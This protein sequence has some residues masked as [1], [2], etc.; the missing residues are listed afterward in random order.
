MKNLPIRTQDRTM[1]GYE[2]MG[3][4]YVHLPPE[5]P[6]LHKRDSLKVYFNV[7]R[8]R[9][10]YIIIPIILVIP[11]LVASSVFEESSYRASAQIQIEPA[12]PKVISMDSIFQTVLREDDLLTEYQLIR[13]EEHLAEVVDRLELQD[14]LVVKN[15]LMSRVKALKS[16]AM[17]VVKRLKSRAFALVGIT[18]EPKVARPLAEGVDLRRLAA[19]NALKQAL[20]VQ[21]QQGGQLVDITVNGLVPA[22]VALQANTVAEVYIDKNFDKKQ[23]GTQAAIEKLIDQTADLRQKMYEAEVQIDQFRQDR[24]IT[25]HDPDDRG[26]AIAATLTRLENEY[27]DARKAREEV[28]GRLRNLESLARRDIRALKTVPT[29]LDQHMISSIMRLRGQYLDLEAQIASNRR[30]YRPKHPVMVRLNTQLAQTR[31]AVNAEFQKGIAALRAE[32]EV[33]RERESGILQQLTEQKREAQ[34]A[35]AAL[36]DFERK[37]HEAESYR[38]LYRQTSRQLRVLQM[39]QATIINNV[40]LIKRAIAPLQ[41][42]P[43]NAF[44]NFFVGIVL[45]GCLGVGFAFVREYLDNRFKEA[46]EVEPFLQ[47]PFLGVV[48]HYAQGKGRVYEPVSLREPGSVAAESYRILRTRLQSAA[49]RMKTL[50]I[51]S[52]LPSEGKSTTTAN[53][54]IAFARLGLRVLLVDIDLRRPSLH[55]HFWISNSEGLATALL[56]GGDWQNFLQDTPVANLKVLP[57]GFNTHNPS[58]LLSLRTTQKL[59]DEF[60]QAFDFIIFDGPI[61]LS[62]P[63]VEIVAPWMDGVV[64]VHY[65]ERC[66]KPSVLN[67]KMLLE[68]VNST[69][70]GVVFNNIRRQDQKYYHQQRTYYSQNLYS[71]AE[72]YDLDRDAVR[73]LEVGATEASKHGAVFANEE[74]APRADAD[75]SQRYGD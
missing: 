63:D 51:T 72:Q 24:G 47:I 27:R 26:R 42:V 20:A 31:D 68:R 19:I 22:D 40:K 34:G 39:E 43:S 5:Q 7:L 58:D 41:P 69:I 6:E 30:I 54:G 12:N 49:P 66:D 8:R 11:L 52:A 15:D 55:R 61:V 75:Y 33:R 23:A 44:T 71:G 57:T 16:K 3:V 14:K 73:E 50:L 13:S 35:N 25:S 70:L 9:K 74:P 29:S 18:R 67:A 37:Q 48:P 4:D 21:P 45:A 10:W 32:F 53:T 59:I 62:I 2:G 36:S 65:P 64:M 60:K 1:L 38:D 28:E 56:D 17:G 46:D